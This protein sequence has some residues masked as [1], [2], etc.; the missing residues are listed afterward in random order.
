MQFDLSH[1][2]DLKLKTSPNTANIP[3]ED[4]G[5]ANLIF[6]H[7]LSQTVPDRSKYY[8]H[9]EDSADFIFGSVVVRTPFSTG[10]Y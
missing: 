4:K 10:S 9:S 6:R 5:K 1:R 8:N 7:V 3:E 2:R